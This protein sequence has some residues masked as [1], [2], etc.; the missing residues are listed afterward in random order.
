MTR[1]ERL[2]K[3]VQNLSIVFGIFVGLA[4]II[5]TRL[6]K[7][8]EQTMALRKEFNESIRRDYLSFL[9][10]WDRY[11]KEK[12]FRSAGSVG[13]K[14]II[15]EFFERGTD[16]VD[17]LRNISDFYDTLLICINNGA[18]DANAA[19]DLFQQPA[20]VIF[21]I[22]AYFILARRK[23][24]CNEAYSAGLE[25]LYKLQRQTFIRRYL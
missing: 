13:E 22:S 11:A 15:I 23:L 16:N 2:A 19:V 5:S 8:V 14:A 9:S 4:T 20:R 6:D 10:R 12:H 24:D 18:C 21:E 7:R 1:I 25:S 3:L 17:A